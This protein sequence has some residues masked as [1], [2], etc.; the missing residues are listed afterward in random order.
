MKPE[1]VLSMPR[2]SAT[3]DDAVKTATAPRRTVVQ[4]LINL[5]FDRR[6]LLAVIALLV[7]GLV[8]QPMLFVNRLVEPEKVFAID[9]EGN[10]IMGPAARFA[11]SEKLQTT[12]ANAATWGLLNRGPSGFMDEDDLTTMFADKP[13]AAARSEYKRDEEDYKRRDIYQQADITSYHFSVVGDDY[14][15]R[16]GGQLLRHGID[17]LQAF[18][19]APR[20]QVV[21]HCK[22]NPRI[23]ANNRFPLVVVDYRYEEPPK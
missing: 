21:F 5:T 22:R 9:A 3:E 19:E 16:T 12:M 10:V 7:A 23:L 1:S 2:P 8:V 13:L 6:A 20:F 14:Y 18:R 15:L 4:K 17:N 11:K